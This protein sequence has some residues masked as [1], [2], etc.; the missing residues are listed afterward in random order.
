MDDAATYAALIDEAFADYHAR[1]AHITRCFAGT[2]AGNTPVG[3]AMAAMTP[4][5][6]RP[7]P[8]WRLPRGLWHG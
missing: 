2:E 7:S 4:S 5:R 1:F 6:K 3:A 8:P